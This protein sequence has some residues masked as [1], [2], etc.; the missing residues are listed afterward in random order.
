M[1]LAPTASELTNF[2]PGVAPLPHL[3]VVKASQPRLLTAP[4]AEPAGYR[5]VAAAPAGPREH[6]TPVG[7]VSSP[8]GRRARS[9]KQPQSPTAASQPLSPVSPTAADAAVAALAAAADGEGPVSPSGRDLVPLP[10]Q[11]QAAVEAAMASGGR[12]CRAESGSLSRWSAAC[13]TSR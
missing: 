4:A 11:L 6:A 1:L 7:A 12:P 5:G 3:Q 9:R 10:D 2:G 13:N 8:T